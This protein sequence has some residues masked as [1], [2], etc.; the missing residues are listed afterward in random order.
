M[1]NVIEDIYDG[2][3]FASLMKDGGFLTCSEN[4][5][6]I[7]CTDGVP[8]FKTSSGS[9]WPVYLAVTSIKPENRM[10]MKQVIVAALWHG[11]TKPVI[12]IVLQPILDSIE[13]IKCQGIPIG[14]KVLRAQ[15]VMAVFDLPA[16]A[17]ATN[18][19]QFNG[20][21]G[22]FY[23]IHPGEIY[24]RTR[25]YPP[26]AAGYALRTPDLMKDWAAKA[27]E[28]GKAQYGVK[29]HSILVKYIEFPSCV[30]I[31]YLHSILEGVF[32]QIMKRFFDSKYHDKPYSLRKHMHV[33]EKCVSQ[34]IP[35]KEIARLPRSIDHIAFYKASE[36]HAW[37]LFYSLPIL[38]HQN[39]C[40]T[41]L[42]LLQQCISCY[43]TK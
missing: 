7:L 25:V 2:Q 42:C 3:V 5:G 1:D 31:D 33:I 22:C 23:C 39:L 4:V 13:S 36:Y 30:P 27:E 37:M 28:T 17:A 20:E 8:V 6:L 18:T 21:Y 43:Q 10:K 9:L 24:E 29:G 40:I 38:S 32:K 19:K 12:N 15:L 11:P 14:D 16:K 26:C 41:L 35:P 34:V